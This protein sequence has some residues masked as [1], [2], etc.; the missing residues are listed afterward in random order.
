MNL[1]IKKQVVNLIATYQNK[2]YFYTKNAIQMQIRNR[3]LAIKGG[4]VDAKKYTDEI[5]EHYVKRNERN[6]SYNNT[7]KPLYKAVKDKDLNYLVSVVRYDQ[8]MTKELF[9]MITGY[10]LPNTNK[11][12]RLILNK[13]I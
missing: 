11:A 5:I 9:T 2:D 1:T 4:Q 7:F 8:K 6:L 10:K 3:D 13:V 12:I